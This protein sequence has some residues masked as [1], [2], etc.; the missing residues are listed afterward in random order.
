MA[1]RSAAAL[2]AAALLASAPAQAACRL[3]P[4]ATVPLSEN[5]N[6]LVFPA[7]IA[8]EPVSML[9][10]S[11]ADA[12][13]VTA[14]AAARL[15]LP[16]GSA[17]T[18]IE[19]TGASLPVPTLRL[20]SLAIGGVA[21][22]GGIVPVA[23]LPSEP[24]V[25]PPV[26]GLAGADLLA[27]FEVDV[28]APAHRLALG[29]TAGSCD[30]FRPWP[31]A[32]SVQAMR[33]GDRLIVE[34]MLDGHRLRALVD[35]GARS[36]ILDTAAATRIGLDEAA[37][38]RDPGGVTGGVDLRPVLYRWHRFHTLAIGG[39]VESGPVLTV[40]QV[41]APADLLLGADFFARHRVWLSYG[42]GRIFIGPGSPAPEAAASGR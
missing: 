14:E 6:F 5:W 2:L 29:K 35:T 23:P 30:G 37:L 11:G 42:S 12:G 25:Q 1:R 31:G 40:S 39:V 32:V 7:T 21:M 26:A 4:L 22:P 28:D 36:T 3:E 33:D 27:G 10:D 38:A 16:P 34:I 8:G 13:L 19:G 18:V 41:N 24:R 17:R 9:L 20:D 15:R